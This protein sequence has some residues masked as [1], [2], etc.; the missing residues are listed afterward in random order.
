MCI[1]FIDM[2]N[3]QTLPPDF[4][5]LNSEKINKPYIVQLSFHHGMEG[6]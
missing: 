4:Q 2:I 6:R 1:N 5:R 3:Q